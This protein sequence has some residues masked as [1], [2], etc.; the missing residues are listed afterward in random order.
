[1]SKRRSTIGTNPETPYSI[2][3]SWHRCHRTPSS[4]S[5]WKMLHHCSSWSLHQMGRSMSPSWC[6]GPVNC[7][8]YLWR[9]HLPPWNS[10][11]SIIWLWIRICQW[12]GNCSC[13]CV[14]D[15]IDLHNILSPP[16]QWTSGTCQQNAQTNSQE[17]NSKRSRRLVTLSSKRPLCH[18]DNLPRF[19]KVLT[20]RITL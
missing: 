9:Y 7:T 17:D 14:Q 1:M 10:R 16:R 8:I 4:H 20:I 15:Y 19:Y 18:K 3:A 12:I 11:N 13:L 5:H 6:Q 2:L